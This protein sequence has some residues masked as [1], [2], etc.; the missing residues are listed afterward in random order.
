M[1]HEQRRTRDARVLGHIGQCLPA[2]TRQGSKDRGGNGRRRRT[3]GW[4]S[5]SRV[6]HQG[7]LQVQPESLG[8]GLQPFDD[9]G[10]VREVGLLTPHGQ[11]G[12][13]RAAAFGDDLPGPG[14][15]HGH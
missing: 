7:G 11:L 3:A 12:M 10:Q 4:D 9:I 5:G 8:V 6:D 14:G 1:A 13:V 2:G 15:R